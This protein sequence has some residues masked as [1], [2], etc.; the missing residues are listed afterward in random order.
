MNYITRYMLKQV[1]GVTLFVT[2]ILCFAIW[3]TQ[4]LRLV[5][6]IINRGLPLSMFVYLAALLLPRFLAIVL[7]IA[8]FCAAIFTYNRL[9]TD[10]ELVVLRAAGLSQLAIA[11][12]GLVAA[13]LTSVVMVFLN[14]YLL[15][16]S[17]REFKELQFAIRNDYSSILLQEGVFNTLGQNVTVFIRERNAAGELRGILV[18]DNR[19]PEQ[20][21]TMMAEEG[22]I[23]QSELGPRVILVNGN[24]QHV[25][26]DK[27]ELS[28]LYFDQYVVE[29]SAEQSPDYSR[30]RDPR[31]RF[32]PELLFPGD[33]QD[34][35]IQRKKLIAEGHNRIT[36]LILPLTYCAIGLALLMSA[37]FN[38]RGQLRVTIVS[39][40]VVS[41]IAIGHISLHNLAERHLAVIPALY[42]ISIVPL[43]AALYVMLVPRQRSIPAFS[44]AA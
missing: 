9:A 29:I 15:P 40:L 44:P 2:A 18:H 35:R 3:L 21:V 39:V 14:L 13:A 26:R 20:Q 16:V 17:Y 19:N 4:S 41:L 33:T 12:P 6:L 24:R 38:R 30:F 10:S 28:L 11:K 7:P 31:E 27:G 32:L 43:L 42:A 23:V 5:D 36:I 25:D 37:P 1:V 8:V 22:A 34:E